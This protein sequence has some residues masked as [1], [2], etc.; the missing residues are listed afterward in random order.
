M[1]FP[2]SLPNPSPLEIDI[3]FP[4]VVISNPESSASIKSSRI[5]S[6]AEIVPVASTSSTSETRSMFTFEVLD[7]NS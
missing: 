2:S 5:S 1:K 6:I 4:S 3:E 7:C